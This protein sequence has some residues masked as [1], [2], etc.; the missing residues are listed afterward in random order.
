MNARVQRLME[1]DPVIVDVLDDAAGFQSVEPEWRRLSLAVERPSCFAA[2]S[3]FRAWR[4]TL[5][6]D[7]APFLLAARRADRLIGI[8]PMMR[9]RVRRGPLCAPRH[10]FA[11]SDRV[12]LGPGRPRPIALKQLSPVVSIPATWVA[13]APL[14]ADADRADVIQAMAASIARLPDWD[15]F[16]LPV[17]AGRSQDLWVSALESANLRPW[18]HELDRLISA[19]GTVEPFAH[20]IARHG[21]KLRQNVRRAAAAADRA[22]LSVEVHEGRDAVVGNLSALAEVAQASWKQTGRK[23]V[24][25]LVRYSG[26]QQ[27]FI[28]HLL[29]DT[30]GEPELTPL[31][32]VASCGG[33]PVSALLCLQHGD[34]LTALVTFRTDAVPQASPGM[35]VMARMID[36]THEHRLSGFDLNATHE[37][38][39][40]LVDETRSQNIIV[41]FAPTLRGR[42]LHF[43]SATARRLRRSSI[44]RSAMTAHGAADKPC[45]RPTVEMHG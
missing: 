45:Q 13:P 3:Y 10:D 44:D 32:A 29:G 24:E 5:A 26:R 43:I 11:P 37:W 12:V 35:Q 39:R 27:A 20:K 18:V 17:D 14:C 6:G 8:M 28:E 21:R 40:H 19:I 7:V 2:P 36:W 1:N 16:A 30:R 33:Q 38:T 23:G 31:L 42:M 9:T 25:L 4:E 15:S 22:G 41:C 34:R